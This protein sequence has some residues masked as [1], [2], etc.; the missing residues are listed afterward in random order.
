MEKKLWLDC[1]RVIANGMIIFRNIEVIFSRLIWIRQL[2]A[3]S[4]NSCPRNFPAGCSCR[5]RM[6]A[7]YRFSSHRCQVLCTP[8]KRL[9][10]N[11][12]S[13]LFLVPGQK[14]VYRS[15]H[16]KNRL[17]PFPELR[18]P[19]WNYLFTKEL[20]LIYAEFLIKLTC[21]SNKYFHRICDRVCAA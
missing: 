15:L 1:T 8:S 16:T 17:R 2:E 19:G 12:L 11:G 3:H 9:V 4:S 7:L 13:Q 10:W 14:C 21:R 5:Q 18:D 20:K 6:S